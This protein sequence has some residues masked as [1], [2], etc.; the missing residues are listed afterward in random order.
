MPLRALLADVAYKAINKRQKAYF[1]K[2]L[3]LFLTY[4]TIK[5]KYIYIYID[6]DTNIAE[7]DIGSTAWNIVK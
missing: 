5:H 4:I 6:I 3:G 1:D 2:M 7:P